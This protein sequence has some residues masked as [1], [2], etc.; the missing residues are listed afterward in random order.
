MRLL[1]LLFPRSREVGGCRRSSYC[2]HYPR[3]RSHCRCETH[4]CL[5]LTRSRSCAKRDD[6]DG[7]L[8]QNIA[9]INH[10]PD[11]QA[12]S[13]QI[14]H[15]PHRSMMDANGHAYVQILHL[16]RG[17]TTGAARH[18]S[19]VTKVWTSCVM[20]KNTTRPRSER[21]ANFMCDD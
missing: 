8:S 3:C 18:P 6:A 15:T 16:N 2:C 14:I 11:L 12:T 1:L 9:D 19:H 13:K 20:R 4:L 17:P 5:R 21:S 7:R 10:S